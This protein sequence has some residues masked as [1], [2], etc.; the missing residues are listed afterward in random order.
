MTE[1]TLLLLPASFEHNNNNNKKVSYFTSH[2]ILSLFLTLSPLFKCRFVLCLTVS[3]LFKC[4]FVLFLTV[5][6]L[7]KCRFVLFLTLSPLF[8]CRFVAWRRA[9]PWK[10]A[11][12]C[13]CHNKYAFFGI[14]YVFRSNLCQW[15]KPRSGREKKLSTL[16]RGPSFIYLFGSESILRSGWRMT[17]KTELE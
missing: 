12:C 14:F 5:S 16:R 15:K 2:I 11:S 7:F 13:L 1:T 17:N 6:P 10:F 4:R 9:F 8:K 3:P